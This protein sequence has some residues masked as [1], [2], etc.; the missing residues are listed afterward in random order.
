MIV[1]SLVTSG[2]GL[3]GNAELGINISE[4]QWQEQ[5]WTSPGVP[6]SIPDA[7]GLDSGRTLKII[8]DRGLTSHAIYA[9]MFT[10]VA[11][12]GFFNVQFDVVLKNQT[13]EVGRF[14]MAVSSVDAAVDGNAT[15]KARSS[16]ISLLGSTA[17][18]AQG[19]LKVYLSWLNLGIP[20]GETSPISI[21]PL[22]FRGQMDSIGI[23]KVSF[24]NA[25]YTRI[26]IGCQST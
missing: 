10:S 2:G 12:S 7:A 11:A 24:V 23:Q 9:Y 18:A 15:P 6:F 14:P 17:N 21:P 5:F 20:A 8:V 4:L 22:Y 13:V 3:Q 1:Q 16:Y 19:G 26:L 25:G